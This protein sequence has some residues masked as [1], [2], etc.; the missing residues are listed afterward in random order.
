MRGELIDPGALRTEFALEAVTRIPDGL[1]GHGEEW[2]EVASVFGRFEPLAAR[3]RLAGDGTQAELTHRVTMR[4][5]PDVSRNCRL[6]RGDRIFGIV[7]V[8]DPDETGRY[9]V[10]LVREEGR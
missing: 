7:T 5:R 8:S 9:L 1:G 10:C 3:P 4:A 6:S 2:H